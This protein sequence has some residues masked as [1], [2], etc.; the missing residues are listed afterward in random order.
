MEQLLQHFA[1][2]P[3]VFR[4]F[5]SFRETYGAT[6]ATLCN[7]SASVR[8]A[9][10][11]TRPKKDAKGGDFSNNSRNAIAANPDSIPPYY[12][13]LQNSPSQ[14]FFSVR[15]SQRTKNHKPRACPEKKTTPAH[16]RGLG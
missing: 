8:S 12:R 1:T 15:S 9:M 4:P 2:L 10:V 5:F 16:R 11:P 14:S 6:S 7:T 3:P 13:D